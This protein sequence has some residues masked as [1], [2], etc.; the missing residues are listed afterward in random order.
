MNPLTVGRE[1][2]L[3]GAKSRRPD[4]RPSARDRRKMMSEHDVLLVGT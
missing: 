3:G 1:G 2:G 4:Q